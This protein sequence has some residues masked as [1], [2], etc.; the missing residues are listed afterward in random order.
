MLLYRLF[1]K[2]VRP[3]LHVLG[4]DLVWHQ[5]DSSREVWQK[6]L[7]YAIR[8]KTFRPVNQISPKEKIIWQF[9]WQGEMNAPAIVKRCMA[10]VKAH[11]DGWR[12]IV[13]D[14]TNVAEYIDVSPVIQAKHSRGVI[15]H[16]HFS[17]YLRVKLL[18]RYGGVWIDAT[19]LLTDS[20]PAAIR[21]AEFFMFK[22]SLWAL[23]SEIPSYSVFVETVEVA[24]NEKLG[25]GSSLGSSWFL[26]ADKGS[27]LMGNVGRLLDSYWE[28]HDQLIDY[29]LLHKFMSIAVS[30]DDTCRKEYEAAPCYVNI[31]PHLMQFSLSDPYTE[32]L[33][34]AFREQSFAHKLTYLRKGMFPPESLGKH[35]EQEAVEA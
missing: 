35:L 6:L 28:E 20:I 15:T 22:S 31:K 27:S 14:Q 5:K 21:E 4:V 18:E 19:V 30:Y 12:V 34:V 7:P 8:I 1:I 29:Y 32:G 25:G 16:A 13:L 17:D 3:F 24:S 26:V 9:W 33:I 11:A 10:S 23:P 2:F